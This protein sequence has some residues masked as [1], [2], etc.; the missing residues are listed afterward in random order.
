M[1]RTGAR[2]AGRTPMLVVAFAVAAGV[3]LFAAMILYAPEPEPDRSDSGD[4]GR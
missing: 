1:R 4:D 3:A 2:Y